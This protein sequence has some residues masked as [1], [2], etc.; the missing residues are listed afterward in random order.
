MNKSIDS[1]LRY[2]PAKM[3]QLDGSLLIRGTN[4]DVMQTNQDGMGELM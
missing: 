1:M 2:S 4:L 3:T